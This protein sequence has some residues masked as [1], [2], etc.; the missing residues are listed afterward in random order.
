ML[1]IKFHENRPAGSGE[2]FLKVFTKYGHGGHL[3]HL[4]RIMLT[5]FHFLLHESFHTNKFSMAQ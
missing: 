5:N 4:T 1:H 2:G 3:G